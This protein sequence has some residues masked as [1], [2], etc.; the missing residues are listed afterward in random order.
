MIRFLALRLYSLCH[1][2]RAGERAIKE[3]KRRHA[4][5]SLNI[6]INIYILWQTDRLTDRQ[7]N[8]QQRGAFPW[9]HLCNVLCVILYFSLSFCSSFF[10]SASS[11]SESLSLLMYEEWACAGEGEGAWPFIATGCWLVELELCSL[12]LRPVR[13]RKATALF[14]KSLPL[15]S[16]RAWAGEA[17]W[18][19]GRVM[20]LL[21]SSAESEQRRVERW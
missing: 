18:D 6:Q 12:L 14:M 10:I 16:D 19:G 21:S 8:R 9:L 7:T 3:G 5:K 20:L 13:R 2:Q 15:C 17:W 11:N 4:A 1:Q